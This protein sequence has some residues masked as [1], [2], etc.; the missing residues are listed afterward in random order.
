MAEVI[1]FF[2]HRG[3]ALQHMDGTPMASEDYDE[4]QALFLEKDGAVWDDRNQGWT[5]ST[6]EFGTDWLEPPFSTT[7]LYPGHHTE[8]YGA[9]A[10][11][12][13]LQAGCKGPK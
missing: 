8:G 10:K 5:D 1:E 11:P 6:E 12:G 3:I 9:P 4:L 7:P 2:D 13:S